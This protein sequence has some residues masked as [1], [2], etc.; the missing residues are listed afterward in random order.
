MYT[1][2]M[3][4]FSFTQTSSSISMPNTIANS[5]PAT[6]PHQAE[7]KCSHHNLTVHLRQHQQKHRAHWAMARR[8]DVPLAISLIAESSV[9]RTMPSVIQVTCQITVTSSPPFIQVETLES[10]L[11]PIYLTI[12][13]T[14]IIRTLNNISKISPLSPHLFRSSVFPR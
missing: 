9:S 6:K 10:L 11:F 2:Q 14:H 8:C 4:N 1:T 5:P 7:F 12:A 13:F 3:T